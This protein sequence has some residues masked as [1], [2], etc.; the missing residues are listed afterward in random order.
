MNMQITVPA[1]HKQQGAVL[2]MEAV[3]LMFIGLAAAISFGI[4]V[5]DM[6]TDWVAYLLAWFKNFTVALLGDHI[7]KT[8][9]AAAVNETLPQTIPATG[10]FGGL[11][12]PTLNHCDNGLLDA[13][14]LVRKMPQD[15]S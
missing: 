6:L 12:F 9:E 10:L 8:C 11:S 4:F 5:F 1:L 2:T 14:A 13:D 3:T 7:L 15:G